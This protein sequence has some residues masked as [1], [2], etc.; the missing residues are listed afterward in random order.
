MGEKVGM[1]A[2]ADFPPIP[3]LRQI[4]HTIFLP[5][6]ICATFAPVCKVVP[7]GMQRCTQVP[8]AFPHVVHKKKTFVPRIYDKKNMN[9]T[10]GMLC[11]HLQ[12]LVQYSQVWRELSSCNTCEQDRKTT[13]HI[14]KT[15]IIFT[16][17]PTKL[18]QTL[19]L[20]ETIYPLSKSP[21][22]VPVFAQWPLLWR[23]TCAETTTLPQ[24]W[25]TKKG[26][27]VFCFVLFFVFLTTTYLFVLAYTTVI[28]DIFE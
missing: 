26:G 19:L 11:K 16:Q 4:L 10:I 13:V 5:P 8:I 27:G 9:R 24:Q 23:W 17:S 2:D 14:F 12:K 22:G 25:T 15:H 28:A 3:W 21:L 7:Y 18:P 20:H 1:R 6:N